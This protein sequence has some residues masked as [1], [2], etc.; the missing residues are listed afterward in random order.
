MYAINRL[1]GSIPVVG[2]I[3]SGKNEG[4]F[5]TMFK[6]T[7]KIGN[8]DIEINPASNLTPGFLRRI[9]QE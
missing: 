4:V 8:P 2:A 6:I 9:W 5:A 1:P 7:G 3:F